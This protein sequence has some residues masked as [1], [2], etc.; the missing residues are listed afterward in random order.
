[1]ERT[2]DS[3]P[4]LGTRTPA[5][6]HDLER[7]EDYIED[8]LDAQHEDSYGLTPPPKTH[9]TLR[10]VLNNVNG[11]RLFTDGGEK[12]GRIETTRKRYHADI[13]C[14]VENWVQWDMTTSNQQFEDIFGIGE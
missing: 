3:L 2:R 6:Q 5:V 1:M 10:L 9:D 14:C 12:I 7:Q 13:Y 8:M 11:L 4:T